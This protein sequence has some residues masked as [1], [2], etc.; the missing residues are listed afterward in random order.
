[1]LKSDR[2]IGDL[3]GKH[4]ER[5]IS[6]A[7]KDYDYLN[8]LVIKAKY[9]NKKQRLLK[10]FMFALKPNLRKQ[11]LKAL[12]MKKQKLWIGDLSSEDLEGRFW[13]NADF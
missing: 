5:H 11:T 1:M 3:D 4:L 8:L 13:H 2:K 10:R 6:V 12:M 7:E 9:K